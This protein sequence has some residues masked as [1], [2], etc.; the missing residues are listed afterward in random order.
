[1]NAWRVEVLN[2]AVRAGIDA[3]PADMRARPAHIIELMVAAGPQRM[4]ELH[5]KPLGDK[6]WEMR[7]SGKDSI[8]RAIY[9]LGSRQR[10]II[11]HAFVKKTQKTPPGAIRP[12]KKRVKELKP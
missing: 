6:L 9:V 5:V 3:L 8:A 1:M 11:V 4:R 2:A 10:I 7:M 12:A